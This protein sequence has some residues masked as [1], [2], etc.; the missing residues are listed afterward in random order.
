MGKR[1]QH[2]FASRN[3]LFAALMSK[4]GYTGIDQIFERLYGGF[5]DTFSRGSQ[6]EEPYLENELING[7]GLDWRGIE[8]IRVKNYNSMIATHAPIEC[9]AALQVEHS[10]RFENLDSICE[11][12]IEQAKAPHAHG[13]QTIQRPITATGAQMSSAYIAA[14]QLLD[15]DILIEPFRTAILAR[16]DIWNLISKTKCTW[17]PKFDEI[18]AWYTRISVTFSD[19]Y[20]VR[21]EIPVSKTMSSL[22]SDNEI[23]QKWKLLID[24]VIDPKTR[25]RLEHAILHL[26]EV[27]DILDILRLLKG[28]VGAALEYHTYR[29]MVLSNIA[30]AP[31][32]RP[33]YDVGSIVVYEVIL[34]LTG[35]ISSI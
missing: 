35:I 30:I 11:I 25:D 31:K 28:D 13:G 24:N 3:G 32:V 5:F 33:H 8:G 20:T 4:E 15:R 26:D 1:M 14:V 23:R 19:G 16:D 6:F 34:C 29:D 22:L 27:D 21:K 9:I 18:S 2:G 7:L 12:E 10:H 17:Q